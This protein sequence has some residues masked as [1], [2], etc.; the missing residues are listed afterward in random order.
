VMD[1]KVHVVV[2]IGM[3]TVFYQTQRIPVGLVH[4]VI[5]LPQKVLILAQVKNVKVR[6]V[7][8]QKIA[9]VI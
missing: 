2:Y 4:V 9:V 7:K 3:V 8:V 5:F 6:L 1:Q